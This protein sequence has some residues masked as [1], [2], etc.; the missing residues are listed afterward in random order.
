MTLKNF[1]ESKLSQILP[2]LVCMDNSGVRFLV[3]MHQAA[4]ILKEMC[5]HRADDVVFMAY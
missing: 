5:L 2:V 3:F 1:F 4:I